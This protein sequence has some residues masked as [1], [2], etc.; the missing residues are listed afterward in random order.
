MVRSPSRWRRAA[1]LALA[2]T[3]LLVADASAQRSRTRATPQPPS[4]GAYDSA[5]F[6][7]LRWRHVGPFR[8]GRVTTVTGVASEPRTFYFGSTGG[9]VWKTTDAGAT[10]RNISDDYFAVSSM[11]AVRVAPSD[12]KIVWAGTGSDGIRSNVSIGRGIYRSTDAGESWSFMGLREVGQIGAVEIHPSNPDIVFVAALGNPFAPN[13]E[14]G[15]FRTRDGGR[16]WQKVLFVSDSTGAIDLELNPANPNELYATMW[17]GERKPWTVISGGR[18][19]GVYKSTDGGTTWRKVT[20]GLPR[21]IFGK[22]DLAVSAANPNRVY[23]LIEAPEREGGLYRSDDR[24]ETW[25][26]VGTQRGL[27]NRPF[28]YTNVDADPTNADRVFVGTE[29]FFV[30]TDGG[31]SWKTLSTPHGDNHDLWINPNDP[32]IWIQANDGGVNVTLDDGKTWSTQYNQPTAEIYQ[33]NLDNQFPYRLYGAQQDNTTL[34]VPSLPLTAG[35]P[36]DWMQQW[37]VGAGCE[38]GPIVPHLTNPD[39]V[40]GACKGQFSRLNLRSGQEQHYWVGGQYMYGHD[41]K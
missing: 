12:P 41:P 40:Y 36:D 20:K 10:W 1:A 17:R 5:L 22:S 19:G 38:T 29:S 4:A 7:G 13:P 33:V 37:I 21:G 32:K 28:Y 34:I 3:P 26:L 35:R 18:E 14:R 23:A 2:L 8:G 30:S 24:G 25:T 11:G 16:T 31:K 15:V 6:A 39:T 27:V 9:G